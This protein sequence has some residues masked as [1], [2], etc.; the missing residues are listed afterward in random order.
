MDCFG[1][2]IDDARVDDILNGPMDPQAHVFVPQQASEPAMDGGWSLRV[3]PLGPTPWWEDPVPQDDWRSV[4][5][6]PVFNG[7]GGGGGGGF[8]AGGGFSLG[9]GLSGGA[10]ASGSA[11]AGGGLFSSIMDAFGGLF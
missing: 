8:S 2:D 9:G 7:G 4:F 6:G 3:P 1:P 5:D 11:K 10:S